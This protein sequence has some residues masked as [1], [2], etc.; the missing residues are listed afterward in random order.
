M[1]ACAVDDFGFK[2]L[3]VPDPFPADLPTRMGVV[4][5]VFHQSH[6]HRWAYRQ[7]LLPELASD[8]EVHAPYSLY[9]E[10][11]NE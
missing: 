6:E 10:A 1:T 5:H 11:V 9:V 4:K 7:S 8:R 3:A 2:A